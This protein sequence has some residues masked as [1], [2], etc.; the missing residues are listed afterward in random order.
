MLLGDNKN[1]NVVYT[2]KVFLASSK[3]LREDRDAIANLVRSLNDYYYEKGLYIKLFR[4]EDEDD[5][6]NGR[7]QDEYDDFVRDCDIFIGLFWTKAGEFTIEEFNVA[8][9]AYDINKRP[10][11]YVYMKE[12]HDIEETSLRE[13]KKYILSNVGHYCSNYSHSD[14]LKFD[15][16]LHWVKYNPVFE[17]DNIYV[18]D[19]QISIKNG[20]SLFP[21]SNLSFAGNNPELIRLIKDIEETKEFVRRYPADDIFRNKLQELYQRKDDLENDL[22]TTAKT[23]S[24]LTSRLESQKLKEAIALFESGDNNGTNALLNKDEIINGIEYAI[25]KL[26][27]FE[28]ITK[29]Y[30]KIVAIHLDELMLKVQS[31]I[32]SRHDS[33]EETVL[34]LYEKMLSYKKYVDYEVYLSIVLSYGVFC[35]THQLIKKAIDVFLSLRKD[36]GLPMEY[37]VYVYNTLGEL[38]K[39]V[40]AYRKSIACFRNGLR[41]LEKIAEDDHGILISEYFQ[42]MNSLSS[43][44]KELDLKDKAIS[45][46]DTM[47]TF[48]D[49]CYGKDANTVYHVA[50]NTSKGDLLMVIDNDKNNNEGWALLNKAY[51]MQTAIYDNT[52][53]EEDLYV[54]MQV[55]LVLAKRSYNNDFHIDEGYDWVANVYEN[56]LLLYKKDKLKYIDLL[57]NSGYLLAEYER[58]KDNNA[59]A[60]TLCENILSYI[61]VA[62]SDY[63]EEHHELVIRCMYLCFRIYQNAEN[64]SFCLK[65]GEMIF[66][67]LQKE[68]YNPYKKQIL[69]YGVI[70]MLYLIEYYNQYDNCDKLN[71]LHEFM[72]HIYSCLDEGHKKEIAPFVSDSYFYMARVCCNH[73]NYNDAI[74]Y[75]DIAVQMLKGNNDSD[76]DIIA[77]EMRLAQVLDC[78]G[79]V[80]LQVGSIDEGMIDVFEAYELFHKNKEFA[81]NHYFSYYVNNL[82]NCA[83]ALCR[84]E[85]FD[86]AKM[87]ILSALDI[88]PDNA[89][90]LDTYGEILLKMGE[91]HSALKI[92]NKILKID[93]NFYETDKTEFYYLIE[94]DIRF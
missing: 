78:R 32:V 10:A 53:N 54:K 82:N 41:V 66:N 12:N 31:V 16:L 81:I 19:S 57:A 74:S 72:I 43:M 5:K 92:F 55:Q 13:F 11:I 68:L 67:M 63:I 93:S 60:A 36:P 87:Y 65:Y 21:I 79:T 4:C 20:P 89:N 14:K 71:E 49:E 76:E 39:G 3:E 2:V 59:I 17:F 8:K 18:K 9:Q 42:M 52:K 58:K 25:N 26:E 15:F 24:S 77:Y 62:P 50:V 64:E 83:Y 61:N 86:K 51:E 37:K 6:L 48:L 1:T 40:R 56:T 46:Y 7:K 34:S 23:I 80:K 73:N 69:Y 90:A 47:L 85:F 44:L 30:R 27:S 28:E 70:P 38:F 94:K 88:C 35:K 29:D 91:R 75:F 84:K 22:L 45:C 33:W